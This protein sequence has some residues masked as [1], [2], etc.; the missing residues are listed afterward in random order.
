VASRQLSGSLAAP[1]LLHCTTAACWC[2]LRTH[3]LPR[4]RHITQ[5]IL[6][7][8][9]QATNL[10]LEDSHERVYSRKVR[11]EEGAWI[12]ALEPV[13]SAGTLERLVCS[14]A[15]AH[16]PPRP[17]PRAGRHRRDRSW[18]VR[19]PRRQHVSGMEARP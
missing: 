7:G 11:G 19:H 17:P 15:D 9:D 6:R 5:G 16:L 8:Y 10:V 13:A 3:P 12:A 1:L 18:A 14:T 4:H 2:S